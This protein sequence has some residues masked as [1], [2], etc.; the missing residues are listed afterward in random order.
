LVVERVQSRKPDTWAIGRRFL[1]T[2]N[3]RA[4]VGGLVRLS[5]LEAPN[6]GMRIDSWF[7]AGPT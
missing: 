4:F 7:I 2:R 5:G 1:R 3:C 6:L